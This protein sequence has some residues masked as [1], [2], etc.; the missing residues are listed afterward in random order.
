M[1]IGRLAVDRDWQRHGVGSAMLRDAIVRTVQA[2]EIV[3]VRA[4]L[5]DAIDEDAKR[6]YERHGFRVSPIDALMLMITMADAA[7]ALRGP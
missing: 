4:I 5:V 3:G 1:I 2:A 7:R 6:F